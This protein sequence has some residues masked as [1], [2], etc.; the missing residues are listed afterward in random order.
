VVDIA[1]SSASGSKGTFIQN[2]VMGLDHPARRGEPTRPMSKPGW[3]QKKGP[4]LAFGAFRQTA[5]R[6]VRGSRPT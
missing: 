2:A 3:S 1:R 6:G 4:E 5:I